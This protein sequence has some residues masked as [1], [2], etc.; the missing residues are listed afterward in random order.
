[1]TSAQLAKL[2]LEH[3]SKV[4]EKLTD[5]QL[6]DLASG[7]GYFEFRTDEVVIKSPKTRKM[8]AVP[9]FDVESVAKE[10]Q[11]IGSSAGIAT[12]LDEHKFKL[13]ELKLIASALG[14][15]VSAKGTVAQLKHNI[16]EGVAGFRERAAAIGGW[17]R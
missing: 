14:R 10:I 1:V 17:P 6:E 3:V 7:R 13:A 8:P 15:T 2:A 5:D 12:Y 9:S 16:A 4:L 11:A